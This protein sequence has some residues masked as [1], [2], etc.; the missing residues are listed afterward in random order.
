MAEVIENAGMSDRMAKW[1]LKYDSTRIK[2]LTDKAKPMY[3]R[4]ATAAFEALESAE[5]RIKQVLDCHPVSCIQ[6]APFLCYGRE[7]WKQQKNKH[8]ETLKRVVAELV[9]K[10]KMRGL[11]EDLLWT[12]ATSV[13]DIVPPAE[14][15]V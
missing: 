10:W 7:V 13:F 6:I 9:V 5:T 12:V 15:V 1:N 3:V 4:N 14:P 2:E 11:D 8:G